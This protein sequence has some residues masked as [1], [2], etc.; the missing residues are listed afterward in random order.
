ME[1]LELDFYG[2]MET[3]SLRATDAAGPAVPPMMATP[4]VSMTTHIIKTVTIL[5]TM[6]ILIYKEGDN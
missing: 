3:V 5:G 4:S 2:E 6:P 1:V